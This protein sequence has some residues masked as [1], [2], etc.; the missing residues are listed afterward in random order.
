ML[1]ME[2]GVLAE[3]QRGRE[4]AQVSQGIA[5]R[6]PE[7]RTIDHR[8]TDLMVSIGLRRQQQNWDICS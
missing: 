4:C 8:P 6:F 1:A 2:L 7:K 5:A 3:V